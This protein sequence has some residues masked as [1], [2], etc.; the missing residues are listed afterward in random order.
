[1]QVAV[2]GAGAAGLAAARRLGESGASFVVLEASHR[3]GGRAHTEHLPGGVPFDLGC[4]LLP[5]ASLNPLVAEA[6]R[7]GVRYRPMEWSLPIRLDGR[8]ASE[9]E[10]ADWW[11]FDAR[12][13]AAMKRSVAAG[14]DRAVVELTER[15]HRWTPLFDH[16]IAVLTGADPDQ[17]SAVDLVSYRETEEN[18]PVEDGYGELIARLGTGIPVEL[19]CPVQR[20]DWSGPGVRLHTGRG[21]V[22]CDRV[23][24]TVST[25]V[26]AGGELRFRPELPDWKQEAIAA[27][28][29][30][31]ANRIALL[32]AGDPFGPEAPA[33]PMVMPAE[34]EPMLLQIHPWGQPLVAG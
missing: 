23:I 27:L 32:I 17:V 15:E 26:L 6:D 16:W 34:G 21:I 29:L 1:M 28:P 5:S 22:R 14:E 30:G 2:V 24:V 4:H 25:G 10:A 3:I 8:W 12:C 18:W 31:G 20:V 7:L 33:T 9:A 19:N 13:W 11:A